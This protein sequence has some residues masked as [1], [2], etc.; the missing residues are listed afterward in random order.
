MILVDAAKIADYV[1]KGWWGETT[2]GQLLVETAA[3]QPDAFAVADPPN[4]ERLSGA[5]P[6]R[7][8]WGELLAEVGLEGAEHRWVL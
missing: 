5:V 6:R 3:R 1:G 2:M 7:C 4:L 8:T